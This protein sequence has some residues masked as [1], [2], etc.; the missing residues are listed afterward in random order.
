[1]I[2]SQNIFFLVQSLINIYN[3]AKSWSIIM[4]VTPVS[5]IEVDDG[6]FIPQVGLGAFQMDGLQKNIDHLAN[7][8]MAGGR[9]IEMAELFT[10]YDALQP[11]LDKAHLQREDIFISLKI[12]PQALSPEALLGRVESFFGRN[13]IS[14]VDI[15][16]VH[17]PIDIEHRFEQWRSLEIIKKRNWA[18]ALG[19]TNMSLNQLMT[20]IKN[21]EILPTIFQLEMSPFNAQRDVQDYCSTGQ[22]VII[23]SEPICKGIRDRHP[24][25]LDIAQRLNI[26]TEQVLFRW[27]IAQGYVTYI[28]ANAPTLGVDPHVL[29]GDLPADI[30]R[31]LDSLEEEELQTTWAPI[32]EEDG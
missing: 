17:A 5:K 12:W 8:F 11:A 14:Y 7:Y 6:F 10:N 2:V 18:R 20:V 30:L 16:M 31:Q 28:P 3:I 21:A 15:L 4:N 22:I 9:L 1:M 29:L 24:L 25:L 13:N 19:I 26:S 32:V 23:N 27:S